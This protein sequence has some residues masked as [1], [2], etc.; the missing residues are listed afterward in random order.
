MKRCEYHT[1]RK[2]GV[3]YGHGA[4]M[5][6]GKPAKFV[7]PVLHGFWRKKKYVC[8]IHRREADRVLT[9]MCVVERC[10]SLKGNDHD[11]M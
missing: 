7:T 5:I 9:N 2:D 4:D 10:I 11:K 8:G 1:A 3:V 6:C